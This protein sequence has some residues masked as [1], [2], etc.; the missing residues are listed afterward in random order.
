[1]LHSIRNSH[2]R[3]TQPDNQLRAM[4]LTLFVPDLLW[5]D[6]D[7]TGAFKFE[8]QQTLAQ[9]LSLAKHQSTPLSPTDAWESVLAGLFGL[10]GP[11]APLAACRLLGETHSPGAVDERL[12]LCTDPVNMDFVQQYL[13]LSHLGQTC[14]S[15]EETQAL[16]Q[17]LNEEFTGEGRFFTSPDDSGS[18]H[19][20][21]EPSISADHLPNLA[22][23]S[24]LLGRRIDADESRQ[25]LGRDGLRW[26]NR[27]Q[28]CLSQHPVNLDRDLRGLP[29]INSVWPWGLGHLPATMPQT[30]QFQRAVGQDAFLEGLCRLTR[31]PY[32]PTTTDT[33]TS[34]LILNTALTDAIA[35]DDLNTW[36]AQMQQ[37]I[38]TWLAPALNQL[39][40]GTL[41][42]LSLIT[43]SERSTHCWILDRHHK[44]LYPKLWQRFL[45]RQT[46]HPD[47]AALIQSW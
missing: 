46:R 32:N 13:V 30:P 19:W 3:L 37:L 41:T 35:A 44:G 5:P 28:M 29:A 4:H 10:V 21:F 38:E 40:H 43:T 11:G 18:R 23:C 36:Q 9:I 20:Y 24:R 12:L 47:L 25:L 22:A 33:V 42:Q 1:M 45:G 27:I 34:S 26:I 2:T 6:H 8:H 17:S 7:N 15:I 31:T 16:I 39:R 14:P